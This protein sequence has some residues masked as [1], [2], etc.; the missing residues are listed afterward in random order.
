MVFGSIVHPYPARSAVDVQWAFSAPTVGHCT[1]EMGHWNQNRLLFKLDGIG[2][3]S[4]T[5][6]SVGIGI[7]I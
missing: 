2:I 7:G 4:T 6:F 1:S 5:N 3:E